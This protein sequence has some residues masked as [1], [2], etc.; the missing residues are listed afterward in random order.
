MFRL[1]LAE[2][3]KITGGTLVGEGDL[4]IN[5]V[6][7]DSRVKAS[8]ALFAAIIGER[9]NGHD[10]A[11]QALASGAIATLASQSVGGPHVLVPA[12][13]SNVDP[14]VLALGKLSAHYRNEFQQINVIGITGSSGKTSTKDII[15]Q[16]LASTTQTIAPPGSPNNELG[17]PLTILSA[18]EGTKNLV[19]EMGM[20]GLGHIKYLCEI[21]RPNIAV[22]T[23][24]GQA[25][26]G[27]VGSVENIQKA[28]SEIVLDL[29]PSDWAILNFDDPNV[30]KMR[31]VTTAKVLTYGCGVGADVQ[32][33]NL[34][35]NE[36]GFYHF[37]ISF[38]DQI[39][40]VNLP[41]LGEHNVLNA[42]AA[43]AV[44]TVCKLSAEE[45]CSALA[46]VELKSAWRME[47][48]ELPMGITI[49][50]DAYNANPE[51]MAAA[52]RTL[53]TIARPG[54]S[55]AVLG[56]MAELGKFS[57]EQH[58]AIGRL[59]VRLNI[60]KLVV[61]GQDAKPLY[62]GALQE[63][64]FDGEAV[65]FPDFDSACDYIIERVKA[66]DVLLFKASR[67]ARFE[68]LADQVS[69]ILSSKVD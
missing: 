34:S 58:D 9:A 6:V 53:T 23:N 63:G 16:V 14:V 52:L 51:S 48:T 28:K 4:I 5:S 30:L 31:E 19:L 26:I 61:V 36:D 46:K 17:L 47:R 40:S 29:A 25:H 69:Q 68:L 32:A 35:T 59:A 54:H 27:E 64:S 18:P 67:V 10:F 11:D 62:L 37:D 24:V 3:A 38:R 66:P 49:I 43:F 41:L 33:I 13:T 57:I 44:G 2:I 8:G 50:N 39:H 65:W 1:T 55:W 15:G 7:T 21:A 45:I 12:T 22:V 60:S 20:R 42:L 56:Y